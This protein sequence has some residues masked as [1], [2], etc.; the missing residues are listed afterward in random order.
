[1]TTAPE[2]V[3]AI[4]TPRIIVVMD[5]NAAR[6]LGEEVFEP[7]HVATFEAMADD[8]YAFSLADGA[9]A[10]L[11]DQRQRGS[12]GDVVF[13]RMLGRLARFLDATVPVFLGQRDVRALI[14]EDVGEPAWTLENFHA[15]AQLAWTLLCGANVVPEADSGDAEQRKASQVLQEARDRW[16]AQFDQMARLFP[17][18]EGDTELGGPSSE[19]F[20][21]MLDEQTRLPE[22]PMSRRLDL[23]IKVAWRQHFRKQRARHAYDPSNPR[24]SG[25]GIDFDLFYFLMLPCL[26]VTSDEDLGAGLNTIQSF[27]RDWILTP[28]ELAAAWTAGDRP[29]TRWPD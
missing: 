20:A 14:G 10:E 19:D 17:I 2:A 4:P 1:M 9:F 15:T 23:G 24:K 7:P 29:E 28:A 25:D 16:I 18:K 21:R 5:T 12:M 27:Q 6:N 11:M 3:P 13:D 26:V 8:G 22:R